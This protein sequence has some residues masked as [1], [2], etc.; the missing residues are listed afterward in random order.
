MEIGKGKRL[1]GKGRKGDGVKL[2][3]VAEGDRR[4]FVN[5]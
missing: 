4:S 2:A 1:D 3:A 5:L